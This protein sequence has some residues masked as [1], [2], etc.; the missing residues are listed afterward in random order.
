[1]ITTYSAH[2]MVNC[3]FILPKYRYKIKLRIQGI[4]Y[5]Y[6]SRI[7]GIL[8]NRPPLLGNIETINLTLNIYC[9]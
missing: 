7:Q 2:Y 6:K 8:T 4:T 9:T 3:G 1:M 5:K